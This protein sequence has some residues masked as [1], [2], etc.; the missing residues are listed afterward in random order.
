M[1]PLDAGAKALFDRQQAALR[2]YGRK[3][4]DGKPWSW[5]DLPD[6]E[7]DAWRAL[8]RPVVEAALNPEG[9]A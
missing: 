4:P 5:S 8:A 9:D 3:R 7:R 1:T 2:E 6:A